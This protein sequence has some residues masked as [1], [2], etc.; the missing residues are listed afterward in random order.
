MNPILAFATSSSG[1]ICLNLLDE[2]N[3]L[4]GWFV[5]FA[6]IVAIF[7]AVACL[8]ALGRAKSHAQVSAGT[9]AG[10]VLACIL[11]VVGGWGAFQY[12]DPTC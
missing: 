9:V 6:Y 2:N 3:Q 11:L 1:K 8:R 5:P 12:F 4:E 7:F 10:L